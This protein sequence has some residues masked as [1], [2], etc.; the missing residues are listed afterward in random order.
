MAHVIHIVLCFSIGL[1]LFKTSNKKRSWYWINRQIS[2]KARMFVRNISSTQT[3]FIILQLSIWTLKFG[4]IGLL[5]WIGQTTLI[6]MV[7][8]IKA[9]LFSKFH[10]HCSCS[11]IVLQS[12]YLSVVE[13]NGDYSESEQ[14]QIQNWTF[15]EFILLDWETNQQW[16]ECFPIHHHLFVFAWH[17]G[18]NRNFIF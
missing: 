7:R 17:S 11:V 3:S 4:F 9:S 1:L 6:A 18:S 13:D 10:W 15:L 8:R 16:A 5:I 14:T 2:N 12:H